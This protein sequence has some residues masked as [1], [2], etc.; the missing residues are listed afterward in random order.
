M[1]G[2]AAEGAS[3]IDEPEV[4]AISYP[5]FFNTPLERLGD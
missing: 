2:L 3:R 1:L 4:V 5:D